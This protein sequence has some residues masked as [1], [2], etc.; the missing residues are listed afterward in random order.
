MLNGTESKPNPIGDQSEKETV[1]TIAIVGGATNIEII[2]AKSKAISVC[3]FWLT[4]DFFS[5]TKP[6]SLI[7]LLQ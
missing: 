4:H 2:F 3:E 6:F 1:V 5:N 7:H